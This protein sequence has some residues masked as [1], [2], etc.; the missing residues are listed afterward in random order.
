MAVA[1]ALH[2]AGSRG[3]PFSFDL[4]AHL[5]D[6]DQPATGN[7][8]RRALECRKLHA[9]CFRQLLPDRDGP[10]IGLRGCGAGLRVSAGAGSRAPAQFKNARARIVS[11]ESARAARGLAGD[12][13]GT[14]RSGADRWFE[15]LANVLARDVAVAQTVDPHRAAAAHDGFAPR[16]RSDFYSDGRW[17]RFRDGDDQSLHLPHRVSLL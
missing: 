16:V 17:A 8:E 6:H 4:P 1:R 13:G 12:S 9:S 2:R 11:R 5:F 10:Y 14:V 15:S 3:A 7:I